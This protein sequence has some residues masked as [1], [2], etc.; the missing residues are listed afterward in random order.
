MRGHC[1]Y[2][3]GIGGIGGFGVQIAHSLG[4]Y[5]IAIDIDNEKLERIRP[6]GAQE[7]INAREHEPSKIKD[8]I[9]SIIKKNSLSLTGWKIFEMS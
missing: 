9:K 7:I 5:S 3:I 4:A 8:L 1:V 6:F 2:F